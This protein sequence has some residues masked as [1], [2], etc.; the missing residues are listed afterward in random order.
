MKDVKTRFYSALVATGLSITSFY[1]GGWMI[2][3]W[4]TVVHILMMYEL[5]SIVKIYNLA[6]FTS[7]VLSNVIYLYLTMLPDFIPVEVLVAWLFVPFLVT[8]LD[9]SRNLPAVLTMTFSHLWITY[10]CSIGVKLSRQPSFM[11]GFL[12]VVWF[13][14]AGAYFFGKFFGRTPLLQQISPK[15]TYEGAWGAFL[16]P[17]VVA[18]IASRYVGN[19]TYFDWVIIG[20]LA[21]CVGQLGDLFESY[22]KRSFEIKDSG[23]IMPGH[24]GM[25]DR[26]DAVLFTLIF[27]QAYLVLTGSHLTY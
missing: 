2:F 26:F 9:P 24:G 20:L 17:Q 1:V 27:V 13:T 4:W 8:V 14:D 19:V 10:P 7:F 25:L 5:V 16:V 15:K 21:S 3:T 11:V 6:T 18:N 22:F 12:C 23:T